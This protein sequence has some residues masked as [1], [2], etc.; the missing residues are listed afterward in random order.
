MGLMNFLERRK[1]MKT[2]RNFVV[3]ASLLSAVPSVTAQP[4]TNAVREQENKIKKAKR[5]TYIV[6]DNLLKEYN[7]IKK[8][9][10]ENKIIISKM[11]AEAKSFSEEEWKKKQLLE[12][13]IGSSKKN[14]KNLETLLKVLKLFQKDFNELVNISQE[15]KK[16]IE[17]K[18]L[19]KLIKTNDKLEKRYFEM[20]NELEHI[21]ND[22]LR[23]IKNDFSKKVIHTCADDLR[24]YMEKARP[25]IKEIIETL[26]KH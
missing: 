4:G 20:I 9:I 13:D 24:S 18:D 17:N 19:N 12:I 22:D 7:Y 2:M 14:L 23:N 15:M 21:L 10:E 6:G 26:K 11:E 16:H 3:A 5:R 8:K 1:L 25:Q